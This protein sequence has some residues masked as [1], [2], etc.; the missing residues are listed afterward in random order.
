MSTNPQTPADQSGSAS[1]PVDPPAWAY[2]IRGAIQAEVNSQPVQA[3]AVLNGVFDQHPEVV[4]DAVVV[5]IDTFLG[6]IGFTPR[7]DVAVYPA[8]RDHDTD[9]HQQWAG[10]LIAA[11]ARD[12]FAGYFA[13]FDAHNDAGLLG[14]GIGALLDMIGRGIRAHFAGVSVVSFTSCVGVDTVPDSPEGLT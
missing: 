9:R 5:M 4:E 8:F 14:E 2:Q 6:N 7:P 3:R 10:R 13:L 1:S 12:D 11:R